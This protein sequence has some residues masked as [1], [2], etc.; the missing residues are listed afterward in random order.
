MSIEGGQFECSIHNYKTGDVEDWDEHCFKSK[1]TM[2]V[3]QRCEDCGEEIRKTIDY[4]KNFVK[5]SHA[6]K[7]VIH[8]ECPD[9][10]GV[11]T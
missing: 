7:E 4:P 5:K 9:C 3:I 6:G 1:H 2:K 8:L 11:S 10:G